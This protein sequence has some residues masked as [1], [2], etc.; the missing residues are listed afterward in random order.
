MGNDQEAIEILIEL[1]D[2][3]DLSSIGDFLSRAYFDARSFPNLMALLEAQSLEP[4]QPM[5]IRYRCKTWKRCS[6]RKESWPTMPV[7]W[8]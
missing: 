1:D 3:D 4:R 6:F 8:I 2:R 7:R 5:E